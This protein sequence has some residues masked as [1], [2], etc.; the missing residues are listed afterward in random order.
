MASL[1]KR[2]KSSAPRSYSV[3]TKLELIRTANLL[4]Q[5]EATRAAAGE[6]DGKSTLGVSSALAFHIV[7]NVVVGVDL[8]FLRHCQSVAFNSFTGDAV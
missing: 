2:R 8:W 1:A 6:W 3:E 7:P 5:P 4:Y